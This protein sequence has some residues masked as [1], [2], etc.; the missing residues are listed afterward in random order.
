MKPFDRNKTTKIFSKCEIFHPDSDLVPNL[1]FHSKNQHIKK[2][3]K[4][5]KQEKKGYV[6]QVR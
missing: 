1:A 2:K 3:N 5:K 4:E 6:L